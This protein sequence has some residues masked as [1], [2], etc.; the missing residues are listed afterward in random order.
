MVLGQA[1]LLQEQAAGL[2]ALEK[3]V[4]IR[5]SR[6]KRGVRVIS[7]AKSSLCV[8]ATR[9][10]GAP[11]HARPAGRVSQDAFPARRSRSCSAP[12]R[13]R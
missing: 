13:A 10:I 3:Q 2:A 1:R 5:V 4:G 7:H 8:C 11:L 6:T 9:S 12:S